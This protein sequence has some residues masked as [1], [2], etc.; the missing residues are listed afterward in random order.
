MTFMTIN[1]SNPEYLTSAVKP[2]GYPPAGPPEIAF[3]GRSN[4]G[5][6]SLIN[7]LVRR[8]KLVKVSSTPGRTQMINFFS[9][10]GDALRMV[11]LPGYGFAKVPLKV[12]AGWQS[13][14][15][16]YLVGRETLAGVVV[17]L[18]IRREPSADDLMLLD[19]LNAHMVP[20]VVVVT[21]ADK[22]S[23]NQRAS[24]LAKL[25]PKIK[26]YDPDF[27][28]YSSLNS[29]GRPELLKRLEALLPAV[30]GET[31]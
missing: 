20:A 24:R 7:S 26:L 13:M 8:K 25:R 9:L 18:D 19:F 11:D 28:A 27:V 12:K 23:N 30:D 22:L 29:M 3:A 4:V 15:E 17:I 21:K 6:S 14:V 2:S 16:A 10:A 31:L 1:L 5:K